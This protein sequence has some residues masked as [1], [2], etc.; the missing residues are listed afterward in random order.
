ME[1][2]RSEILALTM[3]NCTQC[4]GCGLRLRNPGDST[5]DNCF[6]PRGV[7]FV[8]SFEFDF[9]GEKRATELAKAALE[10]IQRFCNTITDP[11]IQLA[12][13]V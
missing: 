11:L 2:R 5:P 13:R 6:R 10:T 8:S 3:R 9:A 7:A 1:W 12:A 4:P